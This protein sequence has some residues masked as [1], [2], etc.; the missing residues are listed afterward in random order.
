MAEKN[1]GKNILKGAIG[2][3]AGI[4]IGAMCKTGIKMLTPEDATKFTKWCCKIGGFVI[5]S[6][7]GRA[8]ANEID[9]IDNDIRDCKEAIVDTIEMSVNPEAYEDRKEFDNLAKEFRDQILMHDM[10][11]AHKTLDKM[12]DWVAKT[13]SEEEPINA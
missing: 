8:A 10:D 2:F 1:V 9:A 3:M 13:T 6:A 7:I 11:K 4:G 12:N 5:A